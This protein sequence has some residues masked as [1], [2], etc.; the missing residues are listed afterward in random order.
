MNVCPLPSTENVGC[1]LLKSCMRK[2][3]KDLPAD[4]NTAKFME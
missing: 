4:V 1:F 3:S 2:I